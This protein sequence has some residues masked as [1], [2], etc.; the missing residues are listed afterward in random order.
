MPTY[1]ISI[2]SQPVS[3]NQYVSVNARRILGSPGVSQLGPLGFILIGIVR[4][5]MA[6]HMG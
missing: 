5:I 1:A 3:Q 4:P 6:G 2:P